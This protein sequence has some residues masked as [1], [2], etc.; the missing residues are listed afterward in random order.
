MVLREGH[1]R[2]V[3]LN[4]LDVRDGGAVVE[5]VVFVKV[6]GLLHVVGDLGVAVVALHSNRDSAVRLGLALEEVQAAAV[7]LEL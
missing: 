6:H 5:L 1:L 3:H 2:L 4:G 7:G